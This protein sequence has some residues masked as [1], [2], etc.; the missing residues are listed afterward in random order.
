MRKNATSSAVDDKEFLIHYPHPLDLG[1]GLID[2][3]GAT[4]CR[5]KERITSGFLARMFLYEVV[6]CPECRKLIFRSEG[7]KEE[8]EEGDDE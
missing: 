2:D 4:V 5:P 3:F 8:D 7:A 6:S 1:G